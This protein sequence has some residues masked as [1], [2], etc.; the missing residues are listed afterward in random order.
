MTFKKNTISF[1]KTFFIIFLG[2]QS[3]ESVCVEDTPHKGKRRF[4]A[5]TNM[6]RQKAC[7]KKVPFNRASYAILS[8]II[9]YSGYKAKSGVA[10]V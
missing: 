6:F 2:R 1:C 8:K 5:K 4:Y 3:R 10:G 7:F 9:A